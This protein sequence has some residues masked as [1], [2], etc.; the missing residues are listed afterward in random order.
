MVTGAGA[1]IGE[2][3][4]RAATASGDAVMIL[5]INAERAEAVAT[6]LTGA[7]AFAVD[8]ADEAGIEAVLGQMRV[9]PDVLVNNAGIVRFGSLL[10]QSL[11]DMK[12]VV[13]V[14]LIGTYVTARAVA[15]QMIARGSGVI[16]NMTSISGI[17]PAPGSGAYAATKTAIATLTQLMALEWGPRGVRVNAVAPGFVDAGIS[18]PIYE[19]PRVREL[20]GN[21]V[22]LGRLGKARDITNAV[23][24]LASEQGAYING[25]ELV[26]D[27]GVIN[28]V[29]SQLPRD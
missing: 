12:A 2:A 25:H 19:N 6:S 22:P 16:I 1:G 24:F 29:L 21:A 23:M 13:N 4:A 20:R 17:H 27:G 9:V 10:D 15:R 7:R 8:A 14:N 26:V 28:S 5:D 3:I 18:A 11:A